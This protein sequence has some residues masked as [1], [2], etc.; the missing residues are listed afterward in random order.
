MSDR[1]IF[2]ERKDAPIG[3]VLALVAFAFY[4]VALLQLTAVVRVQLHPKA[5]LLVIAPTDKPQLGG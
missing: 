5:E 1:R 3:H 2:R 4:V